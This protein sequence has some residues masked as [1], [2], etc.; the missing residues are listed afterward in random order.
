MGLFN[1]F[2]SDGET[3]KVVGIMLIL[4]PMVFFVMELNA[5][6]ILF[7][8]LFLFGA[9]SVCAGLYLLMRPSQ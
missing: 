1:E 5:L 2:V 8:P 7:M 9:L 3:I 4:S 6:G